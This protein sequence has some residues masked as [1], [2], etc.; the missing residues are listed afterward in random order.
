[1]RSERWLMVSIMPRLWRRTER[2]AR[3]MRNRPI[4]VTALG[5]N[6]AGKVISKKAY[7]DTA[8][9]PL[10]APSDVSYVRFDGRDYLSVASAESGYQKFV[11]VLANGNLVLVNSPELQLATP[12]NGAFETD[13]IVMG[14][15]V[16]S[17][18]SAHLG[19]GL[20]VSSIGGGSNAR[21]GADEADQ[22]YG[23]GGNDTLWGF[24][25]DDLLDGGTQA[26]V[27]SGGKGN[28]TFIVD[29][30][31]DIVI[32]QISQGSDLE[33][34]HV[35]AS[36]SYALRFDD[37]IEILSTTNSKDTAPINLTGD[38]LEQEIIGNYGDNVLHDGGV[39]ISGEPGDHLRG[40]AG[41]DT[42][43]IFNSGDTIVESAAQGAVDKAYAAVSYTLGAGVYIESLQTNGSTATSAINLTGNEI[44]Q[45]IVGN[46]G[47]NRLEGKGG[48]DTFAFATK[49]G[50][51]D[52][53]TILDFKPVDDR[54][55]LSDNIFTALT[56]GTLAVAQFRANTTGL[57]ED[58]DDRIIYDTDSGG[59]F[60]DADGLGGTDS[61]LFGTVNISLAITN[62][63]FSVA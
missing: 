9:A 15:T 31:A 7:Y 30:R 10:D 50:G 28:D 40:L 45:T 41:N 33:T 3:E 42:Y 51:G 11:P 1:M 32:E 12:I 24:G 23:F 54:F 17:V 60:Y 58:T 14:D 59:M 52:I 47:A 4:G 5:I 27:M 53:D 57:A 46:N 25:G 29:N 13:A 2:K 37:S 61:I 16:Y 34:D 55:L 18:T 22:L 44:A 8:D 49:L 21:A 20:V 63:D 36:V 39:H 6:D 26:D 62:L 19:D 48:A 38:A 35:K 43:R 56:P